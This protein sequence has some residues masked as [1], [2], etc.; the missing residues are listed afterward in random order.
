M[1]RYGHVELRR[2]VPE[3]IIV[4]TQVVAARRP[5]GEC[6]A[7]VALFLC[8]LELLDARVDAD[9]RSLED[10]DQ[11]V[12]IGRAETLLQPPIVCANAGEVGVDVG[13]LHEGE[14]GALWW[15]Q[16]LGVDTVDVQKL[17]AL[18]AE[19]AARMDLARRRVRRL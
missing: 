11:A 7:L 3:W 1:D 6:N 19:I 14:H 17:E 9:V 10:A 4:G 5:G 18:V 8:A 15:V 12:W 13:V 16:D 2:G